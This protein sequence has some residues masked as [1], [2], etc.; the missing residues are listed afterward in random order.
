MASTGDTTP[1]TEEIKNLVLD[2]VTG[3]KVSKT[4]RRKHP[5]YLAQRLANIQ[6]VKKRQKFRERDAR[7]AERAATVQQNS[8]SKRKENSAEDEAQLDPRE[9]FERRSRAVKKMKQESNPNPY[10]HKF[11]VT[12]DMKQFMQDYESL[13]KGEEKKDIEV[14]VGARIYSTVRRAGPTFQPSVV[15]M[16]YAALFR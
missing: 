11:H 10:P 6:A 12:T 7:K 8:V 15:L 5:G 1:L 16:L 4:E 9:F 14:R 3:E 2:E 13:Q